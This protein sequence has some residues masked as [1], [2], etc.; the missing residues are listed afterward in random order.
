MEIIPEVIE[1]IEGYLGRHQ[2]NVEAESLRLRAFFQACESPM[3]Q[4]LLMKL[5]EFFPGYPC[6]WE[7]S[8]VLSRDFCEP[9]NFGFDLRIYPQREMPI[10]LTS[11][12]R[13][14]GVQLYRADF[15][16]RLTRWNHNQGETECICQLVVEVDGH[17]FHERTKEQAQRDR[18]RDRTLTAAGY[19]VFRFTGSELFRDMDKSINEVYAFL[20]QRVSDYVSERGLRF[21]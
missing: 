17:D 1:A 4:K 20:I 7:G 18:S 6:D 3:E 5:V 2:A 12:L 15:L 11:V 8:H 10:D 16:L 19:T 9:H 13:G 21:Y 14:V